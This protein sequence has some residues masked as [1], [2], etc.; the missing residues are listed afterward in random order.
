MLNQTIV[1]IN[2]TN[3]KIRIKKISEELRRKYIG[4]GGINSKLLFDSE[5]IEN[6]ALSDKNVLIFGV[7][8]SVG[9][10]IIASNRSV[11]TAKSPVTDLFGDSNIGGTFPVRMRQVGIDHL[12]IEGKSDKP[13]YIHIDKNG[14]IYIREA[15]DLWGRYT[16]DVTDILTEKHG[17]YSEV[18]CIGPAGENL[19]KFANVIMSKNHAAGRMGMGCVMGSKMLKAIVIE[20]G[21]VKMSAYDNEGFNEIKEKWK[22]AC[23]ES[24]TTKMGKVYGT[25]FLMEVNIK[26]KHL[27][28]NNAMIDTHPEQD[29]V[30]PDVFKA[31]HQVKKTS[32]YSCPVGC[33]KKFEV[34]EGEYKGE[35]GERIEFGAAVSVGPY[36]GIFDWG[37]IIHLKLL[38]DYLGVDTI[39]MAASIGTILE[40]KKRGILTIEDFDGEDLNFGVTKDIE[41]LMILMSKREGIGDYIA[42]GAYRAAERLNA[43]EY[44]F[45]V[46]KSS[47]SLQSNKRLLRSLGYL[48]STRGGDHLKSFCFTMQ[49]G[50]YYI[51]KHLFGIRKP[52]KQLDNPNKKGRILWWHENYKNI[53]DALGVCLFAIQGLPGVGCGLYDDFSKLMNS[54][55]GLD[56]TDKEVL[57]ASERIYQLQ[58]AFNTNCGLGIDEY[59]WPTRKKDKDIDEKLINSTVIKDRD[60]P[61]MLPEYFLYRGLNNNGIP[62]VEKFLELGMDEYIEK[63]NCVHIDNLMDTDNILETVNIVIKFSLYDKVRVKL[64][65]NI[66]GKLLE[67]KSKLAQ[68]KYLKD[69]YNNQ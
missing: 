6:D 12:V 21:N 22:A 43:S 54:S 41:R 25:L 32:C 33:S 50:G 52:K 18:A 61:G 55:Y 23:A 9:T 4:G 31:D 49:N 15:K 1:Y 20:K 45:C 47:T 16:N 40:C 37:S 48:T 19:V 53:V 39:E 13:V 66:F 2:L 17:K 64:S 10:G 34:R 38:S 7:G 30:K 51:T 67:L 46:K 27:P 35:G 28:I 56:M 42:D 11:I 3:K 14:D 44:A 65:N 26:G 57:L 8:C 63:S 59:K 24:L 36:V 5:A 68:K 62:T 60:K 58:N 69:K 29:R